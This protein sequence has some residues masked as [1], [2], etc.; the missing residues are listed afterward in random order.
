[1]D[2]VNKI[3]GTVKP[4]AVM[5]IGANNPSQG[6]GQIIGFGINVFIVVAG[7]FLLIYLMWGAFDWITSSGEK[8]KITKAQ[9]KITNA[10]IGMIL[11]FIVLVVFNVF[12]GD[13]LGVITKNPDGSPGFQLKIPTLGN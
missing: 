2:D 4:P 1:M 9:G 5:N 8:E 13:M 6:L 7:I 3:F 10:L 12:L 11:I